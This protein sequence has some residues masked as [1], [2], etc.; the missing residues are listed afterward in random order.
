MWVRDVRESE[1]AELKD[2]H[3][4]VFVGQ[5]VEDKLLKGKATYRWAAVKSWGIG[6][7]GGVRIDC[8]LLWPTGKAMCTTESFTTCANTVTVPFSFVVLAASRHHFAT[9]CQHL[10][11]IHSNTLRGFGMSVF[12]WLQ[13]AACLATNDPHSY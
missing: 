1:H 7:L 2:E 9:E 3:G 12:L 6:T 5:W 4:N 13:T 11:S 8:G 10:Q